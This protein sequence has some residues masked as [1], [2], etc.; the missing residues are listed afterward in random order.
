MAEKCDAAAIQGALQEARQTA[1]RVYR[2]DEE[3]SEAYQRWSKSHSE[4]LDLARPRL[5]DMPPLLAA[6]SRRASLAA[7]AFA[8][9]SK[10]NSKI[11][12]RI[13][14]LSKAIESSRLRDLV[15]ASDLENSQLNLQA[16]SLLI[17]IALIHRLFRSDLAAN[18]AQKQKTVDELHS[19]R[20]ET[21]TLIESMETIV[22]LAT[23]PSRKCDI[24]YR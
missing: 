3:G 13:A 23:H 15:S 11:T 4:Y 7:D 24:R 17:D 22:T 12:A 21:G 10:A 9:Y 19:Y 14:S 5:V 16:N 8:P 1:S 6:S 20:I 2:L 18:A